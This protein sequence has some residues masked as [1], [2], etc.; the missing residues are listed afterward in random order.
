MIRIILCLSR[1]C[2]PFLRAL[3]AIR[4]TRPE[5]LRCRC[6]AITSAGMCHSLVTKMRATVEASMPGPIGFSINS[7]PFSIR[8]S[9][10]ATFSSA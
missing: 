7:T 5:P 6:G 4:R 8:K 10:V 2:A 3:S 9:K 1:I